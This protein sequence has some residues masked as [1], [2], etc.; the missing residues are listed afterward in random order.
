MYK[1]VKRPSVCL[2]VCPTN[3]QQQ[4]CPADSLLRAVQTGWTAAGSARAAATAPQ[5]GAQQQ[6]RTLS[7]R[8]PRHE[9]EQRVGR[10]RTFLPI[11]NFGVFLVESFV[12]DRRTFFR[13]SR[14]RFVA[15]NCFDSDFFCSHTHTHTHTRTHTH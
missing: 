10:H 2:S 15:N 1:T 8:Q 6:I 11:Q 9:D 12:A 7:C 13:S 14:C 3:R 4:Q 5:H